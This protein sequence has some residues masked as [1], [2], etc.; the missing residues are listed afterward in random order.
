[1]GIK[2]LYDMGIKYLYHYLLQ[3]AYLQDKNN[4]R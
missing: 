4:S 1:M 3:Y 2:Y